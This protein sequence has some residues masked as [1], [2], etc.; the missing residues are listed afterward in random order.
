MERMAPTS[1]NAAKL[2]FLYFARG[3]IKWCSYNGKGFSSSS[4]IKLLNNPET[5]F[6]SMYPQEMK[7]GTQI[8][9]ILC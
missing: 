6:L 7:A 1:K 9:T 5:S 2:L 4:N 3:N 8:L